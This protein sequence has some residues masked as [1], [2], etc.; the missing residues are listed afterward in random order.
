LC[1]KLSIDILCKKPAMIG[2]VRRPVK[3]SIVTSLLW[4][5]CALVSPACH[6][7]HS[8][9]FVDVTISDSSASDSDRSAESDANS[10]LGEWADF[11]P[12]RLFTSVFI[13]QPKSL[14]LPGNPSP[15]LLPP[16]SL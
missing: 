7:D 10:D 5:V 12:I 1:V 14:L 13:D 4:M 16:R 15:R 2:A 3:A 8:A 9:A 11:F 6:G